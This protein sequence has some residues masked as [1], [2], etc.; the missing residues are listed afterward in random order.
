MRPASLL[1]ARRGVLA[2]VLV[3]VSLTGCATA[4]ATARG[5]EFMPPTRP[6]DFSMAGIPWNVSRDSTTRLIEPRGY[7]YNSTDEDGD[8]WFDGVLMNTPTRLFAFMASDSLVKVRVRMITSDEQALPMY[9]KAYAELVRQYGKPRE[10]TREFQAPYAAG[11]GEMEAVRN[12]KATINAHWIVGTGRR[13]T[14]IAIYMVPELVVVMDY[15]GP[16]WNKEYLKRRRTA[17]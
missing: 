3:G 10:A 4:T 14:H 17:N 6:A 11:K 16:S 1:S 9:D 8:M 2:A 13:E 12:G 5:P 15:E 7:N